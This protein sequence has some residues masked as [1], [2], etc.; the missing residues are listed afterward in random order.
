MRQFFTRYSFETLQ[1]CQ[2]ILFE[3]KKPLSLSNKSLKVLHDGV[4]L[5]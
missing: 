5:K 1:K 2:R 4:T 3:M